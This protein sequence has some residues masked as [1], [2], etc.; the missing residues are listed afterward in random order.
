MHAGLMHVL[1][2]ASVHFG[3]VVGN[4]YLETVQRLQCVCKLLAKEGFRDRLIERCCNDEIGQQLRPQLLHFHAQVHVE[5]WA[6]VAF[7]VPEV[8]ALE[9]PLRHCWSLTKFHAEGSVASIQ[10]EDGEESTRQVVQTA[11]A[12]IVDEMFWSFLRVLEG[13][14]SV[15]R[16][17][18]AWAEWGPEIGVCCL[19]H[20]E[21]APE[22][23]FYD[24]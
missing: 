15:L 12:G 13:L 9:V 3:K 21:L 5:R 14:A 4:R 22:F 24:R 7:A 10:D 2:N 17:L 23:P 6:T 11:N 1:H 18:V 16:H 20:A 8:L 19:F